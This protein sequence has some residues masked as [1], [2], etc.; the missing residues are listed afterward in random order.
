MKE[1][2]YI[3]FKTKIEKTKKAENHNGK[4]CK[5]EMRTE[6]LHLF[7]YKIVTSKEGFV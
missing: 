5:N 3:Q 6:F 1:I 2:S 4:H 7:P